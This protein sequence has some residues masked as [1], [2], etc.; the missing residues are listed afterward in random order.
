MRTPSEMLVFTSGGQLQVHS[1][2]E[3]ASDF[4]FNDYPKDTTGRGGGYGGEEADS[5]RG[6]GRR[7]GGGGGYGNGY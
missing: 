7:G 2:I 5:K 1:E 6:R 4:R 3:D